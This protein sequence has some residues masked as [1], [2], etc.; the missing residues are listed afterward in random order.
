VISDVKGSIIAAVNQS[1]RTAKELI[2][3]YKR[4][5]SESVTHEEGL[6]SRFEAMQ[7][8]SFDNLLR[9]TVTNINMPT[10]A[11]QAVE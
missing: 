6:S 5:D 9:H 3:K 1:G 11:S 8:T 10:V 7:A 2:S 4:E